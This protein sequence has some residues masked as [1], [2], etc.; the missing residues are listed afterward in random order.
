MVKKSLESSLKWLPI[1]A[2]ILLVG[3]VVLLFREYQRIQNLDYILAQKT[4]KL[5][6]LRALHAKKGPATQEDIA[7][8][9]TWMTFDYI[10]HLFALP[11][12]YLQT[13]LSLSDVHYPHMTLSQYAREHHLIKTTLLTQVRTVL[14]DSFS[15]T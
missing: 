4:S 10:N 15:H 3:L 1:L 14:H 12:T 8:V 7:S 11:S 13:K 6:L 9:Q 2:C 5:S